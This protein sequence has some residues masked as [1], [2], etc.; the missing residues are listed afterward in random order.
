MVGKLFL[1]SLLS[2]IFMIIAG[3]A[4]EHT[5]R[6][7]VHSIA[8][9]APAYKGSLSKF[10]SGQVPEEG[11][12]IT[13][14]TVDA[15]KRGT[16]AICKYNDTSTGVNELWI[17]TEPAPDAALAELKEIIAK[18][19]YEKLSAEMRI[20]LSEEIVALGGRTSAVMFL[21]E[22]LYRLNEMAYNMKLDKGE[23][24]ELFEKVIK[25]AVKIIEVA[26][27]K[28]TNKLGTKQI[29]EVKTMLEKAKNEILEKLKD[30]QKVEEVKTTLEKAQD[31]ILEKLKDFQKVEEVKTTLEKVQKTILEK[32]KDFQKVEEVKTTLEKAQKAILEKL[33]NWTKEKQG[34]V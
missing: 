21:R 32:L 7:S 1:L 28:T 12:R 25:E 5:P 27:T 4:S 20:T 24:K 8:K 3:C 6:Y 15:T 30:F 34:E 17:L 11:D 16:F 19:G 31:E 18:L 22:A 10:F 26:P 23:Y 2:L 9:Q 13:W 29:L 33:E 14:F